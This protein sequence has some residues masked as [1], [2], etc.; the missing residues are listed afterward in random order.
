MLYF[1]ALRNDISASTMM[2]TGIP[3]CFKEGSCMMTVHDR[4]R[5]QMSDSS[6]SSEV[7]NVTQGPPQLSRPC[8]AKSWQKA[9]IAGLPLPSIRVSLDREDGPWL[10]F[11]SDG[12]RFHI[13]KLEERHR[14]L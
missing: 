1:Q 5:W 12:P 14:L 6:G 2:L 9:G 3:W 10:M 8:V 7:I 13:L 4:G 11:L